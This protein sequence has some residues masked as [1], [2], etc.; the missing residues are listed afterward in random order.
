M[1]I[2]M[3]ACA[4]VL[5]LVFN[6]PEQTRRV[7][8]AIRAARPQRLYVAADGP[9]PDRPGEIERCAE[10]RS[11]ATAVDWPCELVTLLREVNAGCAEAVSSA[12]TWFFNHEP[13]GIILEDDCLPDRSFFSY[14]TVQLERWRDDSRVGQICGFNLLPEASPTASDY[15]ASHF[16]WSWGWASWRRAWR[17]Y[18]LTMASWQQLKMLGLHRQH[19]FYPERIR[20]FD[21][22]TASAWQ[23]S[24]DYQWH[25]TLASQG[26]VSLIPSVSLIENIG[27]TDDATHTFSADS[28]RSRPAT[29]MPACH[30]WRDPQ[31]LLADPV[32]ETRLIRAAHAGQFW[33]RLKSKLAWCF[34]RLL[35][36]VR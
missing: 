27:F 34:P 1:R 5:F 2:S 19:P 22:T 25:Y 16:G 15:F 33:S 17:S 10:V 21:A 4:P 20:L 24:W 26:Q 28:R 14:C 11:I 36:V 12:V 29:S 7:F 8:E 23:A 18:D 9:R 3:N 6:R 35:A 31:F 32:Y 13:E 30:H